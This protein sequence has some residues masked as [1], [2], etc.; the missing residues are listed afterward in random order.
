M[1]TLVET[2]VELTRD[3]A[4][5]DPDVGLRAVAA[6]RELAE[7]LEI[8]QVDNAAAQPR[9]TQNESPGAR[10]MPGL[11][12][13]MAPEYPAD[14]AATK[15]QA[16]LLARPHSDPQSWPHERQRSRRTKQSPRDAS[17]RIRSA[18][19]RR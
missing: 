9:G 8:V 12:V 2:P 13:S 3:A 10:D 7:R 6:L 16:G 19:Q 5:D 14:S 11:L 15:S 1:L 4:A 17:P 18:C